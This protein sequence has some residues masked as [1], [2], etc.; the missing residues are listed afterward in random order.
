MATGKFRF[1][2]HESFIPREGWL[3][4]GMN[5]INEDPAV[6]SKNKGADA[7]GVG[8]NMAN[9]IRYWLKTAGLVKDKPGTGS[10]LTDIGQAVFDNDG[11]FEDVFSLYLFH[12]NVTLNESQATAW[13]YFFNDFEATSFKRKA[14]IDAVISGLKEKYEADELPES[15]IEND[16]GCILAMYTENRAV[17]DDPEEKKISPMS[18]LGLLSL[19]KDVYE[20]HQPSPAAVDDLLVL[21]IIQPSLLSEGSIPI[22][23]I[24]EGAGMPGKILNLN[25]VAIND[26]LDRLQDSGYIV[27]NRTAGLDTVYKNCDLSQ[28]D[29]IKIHYERNSDR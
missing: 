25:R 10:V 15:S 9:A 6:F 21:Y 29:I 20:K 1:K 24:T 4:K 11:Y 26:C 19:N 12:I 5:C 3:T 8:T 2:G 28:L 27:V 13:Y 22:D 18:V 23:R 17:G 7:L 16:C 14:L